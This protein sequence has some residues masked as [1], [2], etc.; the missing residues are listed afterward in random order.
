MKKT[1]WTRIKHRLIPVLDTSS[2]TGEL[3]DGEHL[4]IFALLQTL[5]DDETYPE[6]AVRKYVSSR[7]QT[8]PGSLKEYRHG[9]ALLGEKTSQLYPGKPFPDLEMTKRNKVLAQLI[10][11]YSAPVNEA[12]WRNRWR[13]TTDNLDVVLGRLTNRR[14][15]EFVVRDLLLLYYT[16]A[17][18]W[19]VVG[20]D[21]FPGR[22]RYE[23]EGAE[24]IDFTIEDDRLI[25]RLS[26]S[27]YEELDPNTLTLDSTRG[28]AALAKAGRQR[29]VFG[30]HAY[31]AFTKH[32]SETAHGYVLTIGTKTYDVLSDA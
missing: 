15:R 25:L 23:S 20:Y 8:I 13:L 31:Y 1:L 12:T 5:A 30:R 32:L 7:T 22:V 18:G 3:D 26:D 6:Q 29:V 16:S 27:T 28:F 21:E 9:V 4:D 14:F 2:P 19:K 24:V 11:S 10:P 17:A